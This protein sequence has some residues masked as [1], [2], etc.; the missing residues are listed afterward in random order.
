MTPEVHAVILWSTALDAADR[1]ASDMRERFENVGSYRVEWSRERFA[2][3]L[4]RLYGF[5]L[6]ERIDKTLGSGVDPFLLYVVRDPAPVY[7]A[8]ARS[9]GLGAVNVAT[10]DAKERYREWTG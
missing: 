7:G 1:I 6:P 2:T 9:W 4:R 5:A 3:N 10:Y 8:R